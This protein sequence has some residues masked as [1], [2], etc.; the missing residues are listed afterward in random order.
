VEAQMRRF[1]LGFFCGV[2]ASATV[3]VFAAQVVGGNGWLRG[4]SIM[5]DG[6][7]IC[8]DPYVWVSIKEIECD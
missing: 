6:E 8:D 5:K 7:E 1:L 3:G 4:W 2:I